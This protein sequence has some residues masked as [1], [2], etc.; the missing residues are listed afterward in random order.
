MTKPISRPIPE[1][2][3]HAGPRPDG[4]SNSLR[5]ME[6]ALALRV[7]R[8]ECDVQRSR[9]G[10]LVLVHDERIRG[11]GGQRSLVRSLSTGELRASLPGLLL[12]DELAEMA[13]GRV[14]LLIDVKGTGYEAELAETIRRH[15]LAALSSVSSTHALTLRRLR[16][17]FPTM[18][19]GLSTGHLASSFPTHPGR[20]MIRVGLRA[21]LP[22]LIVPAMRA[23]GA[24]ET[25]LHRQVAS[26]TLIEVVHGTGNRVNLWTVDEEAD[27]RRAIAL[28]VD[29]IISNRPEVVEKMIRESDN[30]R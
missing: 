1:I 25:M 8:I 7:D 6:Q 13:K 30:P 16:A 10:D 9:D 14:P 24:T 23:A 18:R 2:V 4:V 28:R 22:R 3:V 26:S 5:A 15:G 11:S 21:L 12:L 19:L 17:T 27:I 29:G 20:H